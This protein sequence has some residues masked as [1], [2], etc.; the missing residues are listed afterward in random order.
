[1]GGGVGVGVMC[2]KTSPRLKRNILN[3]KRN[4]QRQQLGS[5]V[6]FGILHQRCLKIELILSE[7]WKYIPE[8]SIH[9]L[10]SF[11]M[12]GNPRCP[13]LAHKELARRR[14][15]HIQN[16]RSPFYIGVSRHPEKAWYVNQAI[17]NNRICSI[18][19][20]MCEEGRWNPRKEKLITAQGRR[21]LVP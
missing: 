4:Q 18:V 13:S 11:V 20:V 9:K 5:Q 2:S 21:Q 12:Q 3:I 15:E 7:L 8:L 19:K 10:Y 16:P 14:T 1:M 17:R 6:R